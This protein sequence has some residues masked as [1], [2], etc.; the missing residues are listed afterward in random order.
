M[1]EQLTQKDIDA[2]LQSTMPSTGG[3]PEGG[4]SLEN[5]VDEAD[6]TIDLKKVKV[7]KRPKEHA[8]RFPSMYR[9]PVVVKNRVYRSPSTGISR[10]VFMP[11]MHCLVVPL[12]EY[13]RHPRI[14]FEWYNPED[15]SKDGRVTVGPNEVLVVPLAHFNDFYQRKKAGLVEFR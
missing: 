12:S 15:Y 13:V 4:E 6:G 7:Y 2:M 1:A 5:E 9:S 10:L 8:Y 11:S 3:E 14:K